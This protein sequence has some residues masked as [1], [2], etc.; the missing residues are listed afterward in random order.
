MPHYLA[1]TEF[2]QAAAELIRQVSRAGGLSL[3]V[4]DLEADGV[5]VLAEIDRQIES[6]DE[7]LAVV[8]ALE[9]QF[10]IFTADA[11][12]AGR[13]PMLAPAEEL[14]SADELGAQIEAF[15]AGKDQPEDPP[16]DGP[17]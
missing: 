13:A 12:R 1:A 7:V 9:S 6:Q 11:E 15:L 3:P 14:P 2:P 5:R 17:A 8:R 10:D 4:G 16:S